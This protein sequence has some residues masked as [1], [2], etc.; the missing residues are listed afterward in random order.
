MVE[1]GCDLQL[2]GKLKDC[3]EVI[4]DILNVKS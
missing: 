2:M 4:E 3:L 1:E